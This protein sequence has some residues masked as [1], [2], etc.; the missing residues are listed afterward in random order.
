MKGFAIGLAAAAWIGTAALSYATHQHEAPVAGGVRV[1]GNIA[2]ARLAT[3][4]ATRCNAT[5]RVLAS[6]R[7]TRE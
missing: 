5:A 1:T 3:T 2:G 7:T 4:R 6:V